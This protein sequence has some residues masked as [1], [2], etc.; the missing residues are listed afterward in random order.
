MSMDMENML[1]SVLGNPEAMEKIMAMAQSLGASQPQPPPS[2]QEESGFDLPDM[3]ML[4]KMAT[5]AG[6]SSIDPDQ[7]ALIAALRP[8][9]GAHRLKRLERAMQAAKMA[10]LATGL[11]QNSF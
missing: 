3:Q 7:R 6:K 8:Y 10:G 9:I 2:P 11:M 4:Q 1:Q 5:L